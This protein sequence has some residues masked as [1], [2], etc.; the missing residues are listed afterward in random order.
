MDFTVRVIHEC[1]K[2][3]SITV[4]PC[5][6][7]T[8]HRQPCRHTEWTVSAGCFEETMAYLKKRYSTVGN[9]CI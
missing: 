4:P 1:P 2:L 7:C 8:K 6:N 5:P 9:A 3:Y